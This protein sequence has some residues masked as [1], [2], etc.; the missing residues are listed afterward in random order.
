M[1]Q[2]NDLKKPV[3]KEDVDKKVEEIFT[4]IKTKNDSIHL[5]EFKKI[6]ISDEDLRTGLI[7]LCI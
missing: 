4:S 6:A 5:A 3:T 1:A 7:N 2:R